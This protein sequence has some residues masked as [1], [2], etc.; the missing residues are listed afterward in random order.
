[1]NILNIVIGKPIVAIESLL[2][3]NN[4]DWNNNEKEHTLF[5]RNRYLP[6]ILK[7]ANIVP[8]ISEVKRNKP[9]LDITLNN[10]DC[11]WVKWGKKKIYIIVG[12]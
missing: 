3:E 7:E 9:N 1:M 4:E 8:S 11:F 2:A 10:L 6:S 12:E 5:T